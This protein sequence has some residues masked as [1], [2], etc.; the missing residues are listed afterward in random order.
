MQEP[1]FDFTNVTVDTINNNKAFITHQTNEAINSIVN[2]ACK[3]SFRNTVQPLI[4]ASYFTEPKKNLFG[5][6]SNF[7]PSKELRDAAQEAE[8]EINKFFIE[9]FMR[10]DLYNAFLNYQNTTYQTEQHNLTYEENRYFNHEMRDFRRNGL[11]LDDASYNEVKTMLK[12]LSE[13]STKYGNNLNEDTTSFQFT[14]EELD[15]MPAHWYNDDKLIKDQDGNSTGHY[16]VTLKY[17]DYFPVM[18]YVKSEEVRKKLWTAFNSKCSVENTALLTRAIQLRYQVAAKLGYQ[19]HADFKTEI[20]VIKTGKNALDFEHEMNDRFTPL[21]EKDMSDMLRF[22]QNKSA[23]PITKSKLDQW[24]FRYYLR[25]L[26]ESECD[27]NMEEVRKYFPLDVVKQG[28]FKIYQLLL[29]LTFTEVPTK[30]KWHEEVSL[31]RVNDKKTNELMGYFYLDLHPRDG[32]YGHAAAFD[33][34][35][36]CDRLINNMHKRQH[37]VMTI[38]CNFS[39]DGCIEFNEVQTFFHEFGHVMHQICSKPQLQEFAG[40]G[41]EWDFV[42]SPSQNFEYWVYTKEGLDLMSKHTETNETIPQSII[43]KLNKKKNF[44][45]GYFYKRQLLFGLVDLKMHMLTDFSQ[46]INV[47]DIWYQTEKEVMGFDSSVKLYPF[48]NFGHF[49]SGYDVG[50]Y[51]YLLAETYATN[52][53]YKVFKH[54]KVLDEES[55][56]RYRKRLLEPG[57]SKDA[58]E[59]LEDFLGEKPNPDYFLEEKG[60]KKVKL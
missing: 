13:L 12:E 5:Y 33:F 14:K 52:M 50:Y 57:S 35:T 15:G 47:Q 3:R 46:P 8:K 49:M 6:V 60:L 26:T 45:G 41:V 42:E 44:L 18:D 43:D 34:I 7:F 51:G 54:G 23:N 22:A 20:K 25:E 2:V 30:N 17:P 4:D 16:K 53:F 32:K 1:G 24:D 28:L 19:N 48:A 27:I 10:K 56:M 11:H 55:G 31:F 37:H 59:L 40:F 39:K 36:G 29:G 21:Y 9:A 58:L 38:A